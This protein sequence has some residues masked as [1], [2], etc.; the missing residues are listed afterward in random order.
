MPFIVLASRYS[1]RLAGSSEAT[2]MRWRARHARMFFRG[3]S[4]IKGYAA[5]SNVIK[6]C[7]IGMNA[8]GSLTEQNC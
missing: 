4:A 8:N 6:Q 3:H 7:L 5:M 1:V 2:K